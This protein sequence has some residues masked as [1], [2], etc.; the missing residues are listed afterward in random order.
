LGASPPRAGRGLPRQLLRELRRAV[1]ARNLLTASAD[2]AA[3]AY[4]ATLTGEAPQA[5]ALPSATE[6]VAQVVR[7]ANRFGVPFVPRGAGTNLSGGS[8]PV[9]GGIV[10]ALARLNRLL[11][12]DPA[13]RCAVVQPGLVN[14]ALQD[15]LAPVGWVFHPDPASQKVSTI[16]G[17]VAENA[18]GP[19]C[20]KYGVTTNHIL[21]ARVVLPDGEIIDL[22]GKA[23]DAPGYDLLGLIVGSEGTLGIVTEVTVRTWRLPQ[24]VRTLL[25]AFDA[26]DSA[27]QAAS[28]IIAAGIIPAAV[29]MMDRP[30]IQAVQ[31]AMDA[32]YPQDAEAILI[33]EVDGLP[34]ALAEEARRCEAICRRLGA[35]EVRSAADERERERL[36]AGRRA[37]GSAVARLSCVHLTSDGVVPRSKL[38]AVLREIRE[39][40]ERNGLQVVNCLHAGDGNVHP[41]IILPSTDE[42]A[43]ARAKRASLQFLQAC[44]AAGGTISGEHGIGREKRDAMAL[45]YA[46]ADLA[47]HAA[48][49]RAFD[50]RGLCNP[51]KVLPD[52]LPAVGP[53]AEPRSPRDHAA[54]PP[55]S[56]VVDDRSPAGMLTPASER[57]LA[58]LLAGAADEGA[59]VIAVGAATKL[60]LGMPPPRFDYAL[61][62]RRVTGVIEHDADNLTATVR[63]G[64]RLADLQAELARHGQR[65][66][67]D[68]PHETATVGGVISANS[69]GPGRMRH[70][71][72]RDLVLGLR[73]A[74]PCGRV[75]SVGGK[76]VKNVAGYDL[77]KLF[78]GALGTLGV[79]T[80][81]TFKLHPLPPRIAWSAWAFPQLGP[82]MACAHQLASSQLELTADEVLS[83]ELVGRPGRWILA[84]RAEGLAAAVERQTEAITGVCRGGGGAPVEGGESDWWAAA[85]NALWGWGAS[86]AICHIAVPPASLAAAM[87]AARELLGAQG[88]CVVAASPAIGVGRVAFATEG[89]AAGITALRARC[90]EHGASVVLERGPVELKAAAGVWGPPPAGARIMR[91]LKAEFDPAGVLGSRLQY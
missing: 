23:V 12:I 22:G 64:T 20:L 62:S 68:P 84:C 18:G 26:M 46:P 50:P 1:G 42:V 3:Y 66:P 35:R 73:V 76:T 78:V 51:G 72:C 80:A 87:L 56:L 36:W 43:R 8:V 83:G 67:L 45:L 25:A 86:A 30:M 79:I 31:A 63:G 57:E 61:S 49:K 52:E 85:T 65:L 6:E 41:E 14:L 44:I 38:P 9:G 11:H 82:A 4:D 55:P 29:E 69:Y 47:A 10:I 70:G 74:L 15:A 48:V 27:S 60:D 90:V 77:P 7:A 40:A 59:A 2:L 91:L 34:E 54:P 5:V 37:A 58:S 81:A 53:G 88:Q 89:A 21:G 13:N 24:A 16:G 28:D 19:H 17:N 39:I 75:I 32:G 71:A 33:I